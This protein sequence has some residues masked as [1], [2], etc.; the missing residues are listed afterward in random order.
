MADNWAVGLN[1]GIRDIVNGTAGI[2]TDAAGAVV[3]YAGSFFEGWGGED[4][5]I[6]QAVDKVKDIPPN[7]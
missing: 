5:A 7:K 4:S 1:N 3:D 6:G 2:V